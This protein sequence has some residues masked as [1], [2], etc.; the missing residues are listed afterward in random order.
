[1][2]DVH[3]LRQRTE[4]LLTRYADQLGTIV[5]RHHTEAALLAA[6]QRAEQAML[7]AEQANRAKTEFLANMSHELRTP[8][9]AIIGFSDMMKSQV[10]GTIGNPRYL[11]YANDIC[12]SGVHLLEVINDILDISRVETGVLKLNEAVV[13]FAAVIDS[14]IR[15][16]SGH[17]EKAKLMVEADIADDLQPILGDE[18]LL[19]QIVINL[20]S[21]AIKFTPAGGCIHVTACHDAL[22]DLVAGVRDTGIGIA[23]DEIPRVLER[24]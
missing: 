18:R 15:F 16:T 20:L 1:M 2:Y 19:K 14:C 7:N 10:I 6:K 4:S 24:H 11:S 5:Q 23:A 13:D 8:L 3:K 12:D 21:N 22:G 9:N 17:A